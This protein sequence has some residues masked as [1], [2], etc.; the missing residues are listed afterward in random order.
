MSAKKK[1][2]PQSRHTFFCFIPPLGRVSEKRKGQKS[3]QKT[4]KKRSKKDQVEAGRGREGERG[5]GYQSKG[6]LAMLAG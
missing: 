6:K 1:E 5:E 3:R 4:E 2:R